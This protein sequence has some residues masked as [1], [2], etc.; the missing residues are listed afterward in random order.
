MNSKHTTLTPISPL[1]VTF[2][3]ICQVC[4]I[5]AIALSI[6]SSLLIATQSGVW[7]WPVAIAGFALAGWTVYRHLIRQDPLVAF[8]W[9]IA[10]RNQPHQVSNLSY[11]QLPQFQLTAG[12]SLRS[13]IHAI[14]WDSLQHPVMRA[15]TEDGRQMLIVRAAKRPDMGSATNKYVLVFVERINNYAFNNE[16]H[17]GGGGNVLGSSSNYMITGSIS[18]DMANEFLA[19]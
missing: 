13:N 7:V 17:Q 3:H 15:E 8:F 4:L 11:Q 16:S 5:R 18:A 6:F 10:A 2:L 1:S 12:N 9:K 19:Q 14:D